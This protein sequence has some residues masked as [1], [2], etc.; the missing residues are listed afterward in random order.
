VPELQRLRADHADAVLAFEQENRAYFAAAIPDRGDEFFEHF[1]EQHREVLA[2]QDSGQHAYHV[3]VGD[4]GEVLG[5][6]NL[7]DLGDGTAELGY[8]VAQ[9]VAGRGVAT[10]AVREI[11]R[12]ASA[13]Y[14]LRSLSARTTLA[15]IGSQKVL[16]R[17]GFVPVGETE[18]NGKP[19][20][21]YLR[22]L[23]A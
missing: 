22:D 4:G 18:L 13:E 20:L 16:A 3:L 23:L 15:N 9:K 6:F 1:A 21:R 5:R 19:A 8:R 10:A 12:L 14:G 7:R 2:E 17:A 11:C